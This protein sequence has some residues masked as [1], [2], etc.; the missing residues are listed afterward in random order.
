MAFWKQLVPWVGG[1]FSL[2]HHTVSL[3]V[4]DKSEEVLHNWPSIVSGIVCLYHDHSRPWGLE[5]IVL[6]SRLE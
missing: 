5:Y 4:S 2:S 6:A 3:E 1:L